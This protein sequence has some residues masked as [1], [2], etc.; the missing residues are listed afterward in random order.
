MVLSSPSHSREHE[1]RHDGEQFQE[2]ITWAS[3]ALFEIFSF[4]IARG[5]EA[6]PLPDKHSAVISPAIAE[7]YFGDADPIGQQ[8]V[9]DFET[10]YT[11]TGLLEEIPGNST[12]QLG[13]VVPITS[14]SQYE[15]FQTSWNSSF[16]STYVLLNE[17]A[18]PDA[19]TSQFPAFVTS[20]WDAETASRTNFK[21]LPLA[22]GPVVGR[23]RLQ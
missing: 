15:Q 16:L 20:I 3:P 6:R 17:G 5:N 22:A 11:I 2:P 23:L 8:L 12:I 7:K 19:L 9:I 14:S 18:T 13:I 21:L 10:T 4:P 1:Q